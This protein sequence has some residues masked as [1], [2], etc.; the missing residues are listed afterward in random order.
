M[1][2]TRVNGDPRRPHPKEGGQRR[3]WAA[4]SARTVGPDGRAVTGVQNGT[5]GH[6]ELYEWRVTDWT[7]PRL[8][9]TWERSAWTTYGTCAS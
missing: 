9:R 7:V 3:P 1:S 6:Y 4:G 2:T 5:I 8:V